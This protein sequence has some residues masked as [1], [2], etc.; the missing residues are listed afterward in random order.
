M[1]SPVVLCQTRN[2]EATVAIAL[3]CSLSSLTSSLIPA[4]YASRGLPL[5]YAY[6]NSRR[7]STILRRL[8]PMIIQA[9]STWPLASSSEILHWRDFF[10]LWDSLP[11]LWRDMPPWR[12][13]E[14]GSYHTILYVEHWMGQ[15]TRIESVSLDTLKE[16]TISHPLGPMRRELNIA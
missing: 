15:S 11:S 1:T 5:C 6:E 3:K 7:T 8:S 2:D 4:F 9:T 12:Y 14:I 10:G 13:N 16:A